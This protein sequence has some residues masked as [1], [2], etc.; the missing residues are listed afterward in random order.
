MVVG[1]VQTSQIGRQ[2]HQV[3]EGSLRLV[4]EAAVR[5]AKIGKADA[6]AFCDDR[7]ALISHGVVVQNHDL[8]IL[9]LGS[10]MVQE[11]VDGIGG[12]AHVFQLHGENVTV[13]DCTAYLRRCRCMQVVARENELN[14]GLAV[15]HHISNSFCS[16]IA[17]DL[18]VTQ[19]DRLQA[20]GIR[21][22]RAE[23]D[24][25]LISQLVVSQRDLLQGHVAPHQL[26]QG[27]G[28]S[29][30]DATVV[31]LKRLQSMAPYHRLANCLRSLRENGIVGQAEAEEPRHR[32]SLHLQAACRGQP[33]AI[34]LQYPE[35]G[36]L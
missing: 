14:E 28:A 6:E 15:P 31:Q 33:D 11:V 21:S 30:I 4:G 8:Q 27:R 22:S 18:I 26:R 9:S 25:P 7:E 35:L 1:K 3:Q 29:K 34:C 5:D 23:G 36:E 16:C 17:E 13:L 24:G 12:E 10:S 2:G 19:V 32:K 20:R